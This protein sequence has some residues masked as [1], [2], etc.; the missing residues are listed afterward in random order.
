MVGPIK[1]V[2]REIASPHQSAC[3][4]LT[5]PRGESDKRPHQSACGRLNSRI[6]GLEAGALEREL[7]EHPNTT[8]VYLETPANP[9]LIVIDIAVGVPRTRCRRESAL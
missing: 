6:A 5:P 3:G 1:G 4:R 8:A 7:E 9:T 2:S